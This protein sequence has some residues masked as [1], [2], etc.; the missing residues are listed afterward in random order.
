[1][2]NYT[3]CETVAELSTDRTLYEP[4]AKPPPSPSA[5]VLR[6]RKPR[7]IASDDDEPPESKQSDSD[8][9]QS[10]PEQSGDEW[11]PSELEDHSDFSPSEL[12]QLSEG[13]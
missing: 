4:T 5:A 8:T 13:M 1:M 2:Y 10:E 12:Q 11:L 3:D 6:P 9:E 7:K